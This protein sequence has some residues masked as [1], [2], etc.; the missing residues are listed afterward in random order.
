MMDPFFETLCARVE[1]EL[2]PMLRERAGQYGEVAGD[3]RLDGVKQYVIVL[4]ENHAH[5]LDQGFVDLASR[6]TEGAKFVPLVLPD[7]FDNVRSFGALDVF[8][9][10]IGTYDIKWDKNLYRIDMALAS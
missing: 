9:R 8:V 6:V 2:V 10:V 5:Q 3:Y 1:A 7:G 4:D